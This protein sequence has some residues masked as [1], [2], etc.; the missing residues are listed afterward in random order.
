MTSMRRSSQDNLFCVPNGTLTWGKG[1]K[2]LALRLL[3]DFPMEFPV[4]LLRVGIDIYWIHT[5]RTILLEIPAFMTLGEIMF[6][7][8]NVGFETPLR[9]EFPVS[10]FRENANIF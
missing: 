3:F 9:M 10:L 4:T 2:A 5:F 8:K 7:F 1:L 6:S